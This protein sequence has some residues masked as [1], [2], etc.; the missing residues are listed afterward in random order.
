MGATGT[1]GTMRLTRPVRVADMRYI[2]REIDPTDRRGRIIRLTPQGRDLED[3]V[4]EA[5]SVV[6]RKLF[7]IGATLK[8]A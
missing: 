2:R 6:E 4:Y 7:N 8:S 5:A 3:R 1:R